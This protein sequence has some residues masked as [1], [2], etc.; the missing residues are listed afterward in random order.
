ML[1]HLAR[2]GYLYMPGRQDNPLR[3]EPDIFPF[4]NLHCFTTFLMLTPLC[5]VRAE[6]V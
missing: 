5:G 3:H 4:A 2:Q 1:L 6:P